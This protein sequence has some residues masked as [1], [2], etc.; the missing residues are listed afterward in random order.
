VTIIM[1]MKVHRAS[2]GM[3]ALAVLW[4]MILIVTCVGIAVFTVLASL[5][6]KH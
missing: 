3:A 5:A 2:G 1:V 4:W 6:A